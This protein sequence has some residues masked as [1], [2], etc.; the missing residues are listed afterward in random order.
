[1]IKIF[2]VG[3]INLC[4]DGVGAKVIKSIKGELELNSNVEVIIGEM[5]FTNCLDRINNDD[6]V[7]IVDGTYFDLRPGYVSKLSFDECDNLMAESINQNNSDSLYKIIRREYRGLK[8]YLVGIEINKIESSLD[9]SPNLKE[10]FNSIC[11]RVL[12]KIRSL[13]IVNKNRVSC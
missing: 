11:N 3:N 2:G 7:I 10:D 9:L 8:G 1:M 5:D 6:F 4:D 12:D 13:I